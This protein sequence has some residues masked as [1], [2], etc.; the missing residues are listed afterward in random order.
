FFVVPLFGFANAGLSFTGVG[1]N[2]LMEPVALGVGLGLLLGKLVGVLGSV[3]MMVK[4]GVADLPA[5]AS[6]RQ[7]TGVALLCGIGFTMSLFVALLAFN[8]PIAQD[9]AKLGI[10][11]GST[12]AAILGCMVLIGSDRRGMKHSISSG[13]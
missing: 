1:I 7:M 5:T 10:I 6:W 2:S 12:L 13:A 3:W 11:A 4:M 8:D 9:Q